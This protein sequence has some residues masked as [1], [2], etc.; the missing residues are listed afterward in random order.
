MDPKPR[1]IIFADEARTKLMTGVNKLADA[2]R[3]TLGPKGRNVVF[4]REFQGPHVTKDG[5]TVAQEVTLEDLTENLG[6]QMMQQACSKTADVA[7]DGTTTAAII[8]QSIVNEGMKLVSA[9]MNP[10]DLKRGIDKATSAIVDEL[11][12]ISQKCDTRK[13]IEQVATISSN[14]DKTIGKLIADAIDTVGKS[15]VIT[16]EEGQG[17]EDSLNVVEGIEFE[18]GY[19]SP[20][21]VTNV[22]KQKTELE[23][24]YICVV[25]D[26]ITLIKE[27]VP[28]LE[29]VVDT[30]RPLLMIVEE[31]YP[32]TLNLLVA[33][34]VRGTMQVCAVKIPGFGENG[35][36]IA[37]DIA[38][39]ANATVISSDLGLPLESATL[40]HLGTATRV[41]ISKDKTLIITDEGSKTTI[42]KR[43]EALRDQYE[44]AEAEYDKRKIE[45]RIANLLGGVAVIRAGAATEVEMKEKTDRI[46]DALSATRAAIEDGIVPGGGVALIR[47]KQKVKDSLKGDNIDQ[48]AGIN[49]VLKAIESPMRQI[50]ENAGASADVNM[51]EV[52]SKANSYGYDASSGKFG[53]MIDLGII[54][55]TKVTKTALV[56]AASV[57]GMFL[58]TECSITP[59]EAPKPQVGDDYVPD[60][61][62]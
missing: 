51:A 27:I 6:A 18:R 62:R 55:P 46:D 33:N 11:S 32:E 37:E 5:V 35:D 59:I 12:S 29:D 57:A 44:A 10:M 15:G 9:G 17:L 2:V 49:T 16:V 3:I 36:G 43:V 41:E 8:A 7:G 52:L 26:D 19:L 39:M 21:F 22:A 4:H 48:D 38:S 14:S 56:N 30:G 20:Y 45:E 60:V 40:E 13:E 54:D 53:D 24:P 34:H 31:I 42:E 58:I 61:L 47:A 28:I 50:S 1:N 23:N 25:N